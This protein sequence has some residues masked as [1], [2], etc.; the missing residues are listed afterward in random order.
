VKGGSALELRLGLAQSRTSKDL[1]AVVRGSLDDFVTRADKSRAGLAGFTG[2]L[3][4]VREGARSRH[5][6]EAAPVQVALSYKGKAFATVP[7]EISRPRAAPPPSS[8]K[9]TRRR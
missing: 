6:C 5:E 7:V 4:D 3:K 9:S 2:K 8:R 1:D